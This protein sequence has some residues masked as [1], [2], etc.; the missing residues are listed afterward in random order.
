LGFVIG[1][2]DSL[3][4]QWFSLCEDLEGTDR[5]NAAL[6]S[7]MT[8]QQVMVASARRV[9]LGGCGAVIPVSCTLSKCTYVQYGNTIDSP[10]QPYSPF[11]QQITRCFL[12]C[13]SVL[14]A[15]SDCHIINIRC[16]NQDRKLWIR[17][18]LYHPH[19]G[20][21]YSKLPSY[22]SYDYGSFINISV[23]DLC[24]SNL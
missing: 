24:L 17:P 11:T 9:G 18:M 8:N 19:T 2:L 12:Y 22:L 7:S 23:M 4:K 20:F 16:F 3:R 5:L 21:R 1:D 15:L 13:F 10:H 6:S 14:W